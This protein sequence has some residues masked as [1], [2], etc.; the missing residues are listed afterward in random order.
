VAL[1]QVKGEDHLIY[2]LF[3]PEGQTGKAWEPS[4]SNAFSVIGKHWIE[5][6]IHFLPPSSYISGG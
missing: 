1:E 6:Y 4:K 3:L 5:K 2:T